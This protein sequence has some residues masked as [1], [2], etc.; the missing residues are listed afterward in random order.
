MMAAFRF[1]AGAG[2]R[3]L[4]CRCRWDNFMEESVI[5]VISN[6]CTATSSERLYCVTYIRLLSN[7][8]IMTTPDMMRTR[9]IMNVLRQ[10]V[11]INL[12]AEL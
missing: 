2:V 10:N 4:A 7:D 6:T 5:N 8:I 9:T 11:N 12:W 1:T 3:W